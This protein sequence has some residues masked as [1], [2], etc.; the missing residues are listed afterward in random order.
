MMNDTY[1][2]VIDRVVD[3]DTAVLLVEHD[4]ER[5]QI[6]LDVEELPAGANE[7][8]VV[9]VTISDG[10][11][12]SITYL[13]DKTEARRQRTQDRFDQLSKRLPD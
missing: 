9:E 5:N 13:E 7:G 3:N 2:A 8:A 10:D 4:G 11:V 1:E 12:I 6:E